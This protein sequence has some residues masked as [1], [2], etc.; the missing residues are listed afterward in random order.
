[1][2]FIESKQKFQKF[3]WCPHPVTIDKSKDWGPGNMTEFP[4]GVFLKHD[5][6]TG[7]VTHGVQPNADKTAPVGWIK[8]NLTAALMVPSTYQYF[9]KSPIWIEDETLK[10]DTVVKTL[11]GVIEYKYDPLVASVICYNGCA[12]GPYMEDAWV[13]TVKNIEK[14]YVLS[15]V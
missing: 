15:P 7:D 12:N 13:Q 6:S 4:D 10:E 8:S 11:D 14:N 9:D 1:M 5:G 2:L 3:S